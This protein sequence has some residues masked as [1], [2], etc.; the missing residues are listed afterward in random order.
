MQTERTPTQIARRAILIYEQS[1]EEAK[2]CIP[3]YI[4]DG[5]DVMWLLA[6]TRGTAIAHYAGEMGCRFTN[7]RCTRDYMRISLQAIRDEAGDL[8]VDDSFDD[9][10]IPIAYTWEDEGWTWEGCDRKD[11]RGVAFWRCEPRPPQDKEPARG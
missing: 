2:D 3:D 8:A 4:E 9:D 7:V 10:E 6:E 5:C 11:P 1:V